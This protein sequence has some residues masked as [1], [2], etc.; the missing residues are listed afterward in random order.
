MTI[1]FW[2]NAPPGTLAVAVRNAASNR[3]YIA[4]VATTAGWQFKTVTIP[5]D[6][7]GT[8]LTDNS[9]GAV[10]S[11]CFG[12][13]SNCWSAANIWA[14]NSSFATSATSNF[15][16]MLRQHLPHRRH[17]AARQRCTLAPH[18]RRSSCNRLIRNC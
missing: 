3:S 18:A 13:G 9:I 4:N 8:W 10:I 12:A 6:T 7:A 11:F 2:V 15:I 17:S 16:G 14:A 5:G 1:A